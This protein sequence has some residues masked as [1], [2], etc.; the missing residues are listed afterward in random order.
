LT[1]P[2]RPVKKIDMSTI[3]QFTE[4]NMLRGLVDWA[5]DATGRLKM[6]HP[7]LEL[8]PEYAR[9]WDI[10]KTLPDRLDEVER[11]ARRLLDDPHLSAFMATQRSSGVPVLWTAPVL[12]RECDGDLARYLGN[13]DR[14]DRPTID[15]P[16]GRGPFANFQLGAA[17][18]LKYDHVDEVDF[19][20]IERMLYEQELWNGFGYRNKPNPKP[21]PYLVGG[22][23]L[24]QF[25]K[26]TGD[27]R[28]DPHAMD[29]QLGTIPIAKRMIELRPDVGLARWH[30]NGQPLGLQ[31]VQ[32]PPEGLG[33]THDTAW[34]Q[35]A[36]NHLGAQLVV[37]GSYGRRTR[38]AVID[39]Q[40]HHAITADGIVGPVTI[41]A[42]S[43]ALA[44]IGVVKNPD[45][46]A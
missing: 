28:W 5:I 27:G 43:A 46:V 3:P 44:A 13:G 22:T 37:D 4:E 29:T 19:W 15:V 23:T 36:L 24:Q 21:S 40:S 6:A 11:A 7:F 10:A 41:G 45:S 33:G 18:A 12:E 38:N 14:L 1:P 25:G 26:Y 16:R 17:D 30:G 9:W 8:A 31:P 35:G 34:V 39:F 32:P 2:S 20:T 42:L